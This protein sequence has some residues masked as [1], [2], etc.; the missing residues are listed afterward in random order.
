MSKREPAVRAFI[1]LTATVVY[2]LGVMTLI[3]CS[4]VQF[5]AAQT[6]SNG[7]VITTILGDSLSAGSGGFGQLPNW[8]TQLANTG[9]L[10][11]GS[12]AYNFAGNGDTSS[13]V[14]SP[15]SSAAANLVA[16]GL[17]DYA[18]IV[19]GGND[20]ADAG[21]TAVSAGS[22]SAAAA[23]P[24]TYANNVQNSVAQ[25]KSAGDINIVL[26]NIPDITV[27]PRVQLLNAPP[28][29][30]SQ[31]RSLIES[32]NSQLQSYAASQG[33]PVIDL[34]SF[35]QQVLDNT[36]F[37]LGGNHIGVDAKVF[38]GTS[39]FTPDGFHADPAAHGL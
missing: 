13:D 7:P 21:Q 29:L 22:V 35:S 27:T 39:L 30:L 32:A 28:F 5:T 20:A 26:A 8:H 33:I 12:G 6:S 34:Y 4:A 38:N 37:Q 3:A 19:I 9:Q 18:A 25:L 23:F 31:F 16:Q 2:R 24:S 10:S 14:V 11:T 17:V 36:P 15:Q 1:R